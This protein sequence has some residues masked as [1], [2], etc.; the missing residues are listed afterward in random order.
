MPNELAISDYLRQWGQFLDDDF[1][2]MPLAAP[3]QPFDIEIPSDGILFDPAGLGEQTMLM[4][5]SSFAMVD[6]VRQQVNLITAFIEGSN[7]YGSD[8]TRAEALSTMGGT[9]RIKTSADNLMTFNTDG[10][11]NADDDFDQSLFLAGAVRSNEQ[12]AFAAIHT[13]FMREHNFWVDSIARSRPGT[14]GNEIYEC[15]RAIVAAQ[16][17]AI[18]YNELLPLLLGE[19]W[20]EPCSGYD[21]SVDPGITNVFTAAAF[22]VGHTMHS[23]MTKREDSLMMAAPEGALGLRDAFL[24]A[25]AGDRPLCRR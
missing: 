20:I 8:A 5:R 13:L 22:R 24:K 7:V 2:E 15:A 9:G 3:A 10:I 6:G 12:T 19:D 4:D 23:S 11:P 21:P 25:R 14:S 17:Q 18:T 1:I 16:Q